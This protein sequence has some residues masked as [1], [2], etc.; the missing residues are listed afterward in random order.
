MNKTSSDTSTSA[1]SLVDMPVY[2]QQ[3]R[4]IMLLGSLGFALVGLLAALGIIL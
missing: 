4:Y 3:W 1:P 2:E